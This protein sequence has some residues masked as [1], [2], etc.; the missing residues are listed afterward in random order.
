MSARRP[1]S[2]GSRLDWSHSSPRSIAAFGR[3]CTQPFTCLSGAGEV[4]VKEL[5]ERYRERAAVDRS[6]RYIRGLRQKL[7]DHGLAE[8][9]GSKT[10]RRYVA[11]EP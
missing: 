5:Y 4:P 8:A 10:N 2:S 6:D 7:V 3:G 11:L 9:V 1:R